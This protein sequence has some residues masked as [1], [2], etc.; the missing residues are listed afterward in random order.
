MSTRPQRLKLAHCLDKE[1]NF[2]KNGF[3]EPSVLE[4]RMRLS[5]SVP[6]SEG[7][8]RPRLLGRAGG[9]GRMPGPSEARI[10]TRSARNVWKHVS[11]HSRIFFSP[12]L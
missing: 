1:A 6:C 8:W 11:P 2:W 10:H 3:E 4:G 9:A 7:A 12:L 5:D